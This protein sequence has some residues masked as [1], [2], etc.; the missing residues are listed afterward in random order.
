M[1]CLLANGA[2]IVKVRRFC[3]VIC[4]VVHRGD[5]TCDI[6]SGHLLNRGIRKLA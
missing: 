6:F 1:C 2:I 3:E 5:G 4:T